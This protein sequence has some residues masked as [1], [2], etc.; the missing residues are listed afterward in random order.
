VLAV[1]RPVGGSGRQA[2]DLG[3][4]EIAARIAMASFA[5]ETLTFRPRPQASPYG[6]CSAGLVLTGAVLGAV[7]L[8]GP[9]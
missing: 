8:L 2:G 6:W 5:E 3:R 9:L 4:A 7:F 1:L